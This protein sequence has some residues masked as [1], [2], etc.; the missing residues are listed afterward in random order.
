MDAP[1]CRY[2]DHGLRSCSRG[3]GAGWDAEPAGPV[4]Y[5]ASRVLVSRPCGRFSNMFVICVGYGGRG[6]A[7]GEV[8]MHAR[9]VVAGGGTEGA[10]A[11]EGAGVSACLERD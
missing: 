4:C 8:P 9:A 11:Q 2:G 6:R 10:A 7:A 5:T 1:R 3:G